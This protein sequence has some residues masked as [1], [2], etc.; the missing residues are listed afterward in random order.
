M[1]SH[2]LPL[3]GIVSVALHI[4]PARRHFRAFWAVTMALCVLTVLTHRWV[5]TPHD[6]GFW[7]FR[8]LQWL[9]ILMSHEHH[10]LHHDSLMRQ[11]SNLS[12]V[13]DG[14][15]DYIVENW[16]PAT[17]YQHWLTIVLVYFAL[18]IV[19]GSEFICRDRKVL[20]DTDDDSSSSKQFWLVNLPKEV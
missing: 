20:P 14:I 1:L 7:W 6:E 11:F 10:M 15:L 8:L 4:V 17:E 13:T 18:P 9:G 16:L 12:G 5:H 3:I 19:V 2:S